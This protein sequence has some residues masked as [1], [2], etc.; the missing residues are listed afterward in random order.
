MFFLRDGQRS[1]QSFCI[2]QNLRSNGAIS[3]F[4]LEGGVLLLFFIVCTFALRA[5]FSLHF[6]LYLG[7][8]SG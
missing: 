1:C 5:V 4:F 8:K 2:F 7:L 6:V 3:E